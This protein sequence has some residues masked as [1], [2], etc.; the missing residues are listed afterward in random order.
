MYILKFTSRF[1]KNYKLMVKQGKDISLLDE[2]IEALRLEK[3][4]DAKYK[5]HQL[6]GNFRLFRECHIKPDWLL[7]YMIENDVLT[8]TLI[9]T[10]SHSNLLKM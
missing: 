2:V 10:G 9:D 5:D 6:T 7:I 8:L 1:K 4:L 3:T